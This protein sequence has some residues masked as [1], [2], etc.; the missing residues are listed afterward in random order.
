MSAERRAVVIAGGGTGGHVFPGLALAAE[1][2][3]REPARPVEWI[4][5]QG[6]LEEKLVP[7]VDLPLSLLPLSG[8]ARMGLVRG[9]RSAGLAGAATL[10]LVA[11]F[12]R[13]RPLLLVG[14]GGFASG[15]AVLAGA[16]AGTPVLLLEQNAV[17]GG[18]NRWLS[19]VANAAA[20]T[21]DETTD[22]LRCRVVITG[23]PVRVDIAA[24]PAR[25]AGPV[26]EILGFGGSRGARALNEAWIGALPLLADVP[27]R[28][29]I[30]TGPADAERVAAAAAAS[31]AR[32]EVLPFLDDMPRRLGAAD[33]VVARAGATTVAELTAAGRAALLVPFPQAAND[34]QLA[35][36]RAL[37]ARG[38]ALLVEQRE[39]TPDRLA[40][41]VRELVADPAR[42]DAMGRA[43][44][45]LGRPDAAARVAD[46]AEEL[47]GV[48]A[49]REAA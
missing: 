46:L 20:A 5:A 39:L 35:N 8:M 24:L 31:G 12:R 42:V 45:A 27:A 26:R 33:L 1:L 25:P 38:A 48:R 17:A 37:A 30:Q 40:A 49:P 15:P 29:V 6:G 7:A 41:L 11:R 34:H 32:A 9:V 14:V 19:H 44:R 28:F 4:G 43:A 23:N 2:L 21:F 22:Q 36:A 47:L 3:R 16:L 18:T 10:R 13:E